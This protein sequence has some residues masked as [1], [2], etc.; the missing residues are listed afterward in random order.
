MERL[1]GVVQE[2][3]H[4][5]DI[6]TV[7]AIVRTAARAL[8]GADGAT[9][10]L[11]DGDQCYYAD[12]DAIS[13][14]WK[15]KRFPM[16]ACISGWVM[17]HAQPVVIEDIYADPRIPADA[18]RPTFVKSLAMVPIRRDAPIGAIGNYWAQ[19]R[20]PT[21]KEVHILQAL[22]DTTSVALENAELYTRLL[23]QVETLRQQREHILKQHDTLEVFTRALAH[24]LREPARTMISFSRMLG[25]ADI[26]PKKRDTYIR[27]VQ[28]ASERM[29]M[30]ID[31]VFEYMQLDD[32]AGSSTE[33][34][35]MQAVL[36]GVGSNLARLTQERR[37]TLLSESLPRVRANPTQMM[38]LLQNLIVNAIRHNENGVTVDVHAEERADSWLFS[39]HDNG[40]GIAREQLDAIFL[41]FKRLTHR[42]G[43]AGLGL[44]IC[45]KIVNSHGGEIWCESSPGAGTT[46]FFTIPNKGVTVND[47]ASS[48]HLSTSDTASRDPASLHLLV[49]DDM[50]ADIEI[51]RVLLRK[52]KDPACKVT[53]ARDGDEALGILKE[54]GNGSEGIDLVLLDINMPGMDGFDLLEKIRGDAGLQNTAVV[55]CSGSSYEQDMKRAESLGALGYLVKPPSNDKL[56]PILE[57]VAAR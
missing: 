26:P 24:D 44:A 12:E 30:L 51:A 13:P 25:D 28:D 4:A 54:H 45:K 56:G 21:E 2:L 34:C 6:E 49:V 8:T 41:P 10:V 31:T 57:R 43:C 5:R 38:Q 48:L 32:P 35:A 46:F 40:A 17:L 53:I 11:R 15:G 20:L 52:R 55:M 7:S 36:E 47:S 14:L 27:Y 50:E 9:F 39:V 18:Y 29:G 16:E 37:A 1:V 19:H 23:E 33:P 22:A 3:S 42:Q